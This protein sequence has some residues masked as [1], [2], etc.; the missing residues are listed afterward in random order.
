MEPH[1]RRVWIRFIDTQKA[2]HIV[3][4]TGHDAARSVS[5]SKR[6][7]DLVQHRADASGEGGPERATEAAIVQEVALVNT[8][9]IQAAGRYLSQV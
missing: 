1:V 4:P 5:Q 8:N 7:A 2:I 6:M 3:K 9:I